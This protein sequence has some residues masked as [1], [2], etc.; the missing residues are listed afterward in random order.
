MGNNQTIGFKA[1]RREDKPKLTKTRTPIV[2]A[3]KKSLEVPAQTMTI[4]E[5][6]VPII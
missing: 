4:A 3:L 5:A 1:I 6:N 2:L